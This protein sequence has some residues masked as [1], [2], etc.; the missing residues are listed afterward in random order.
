MIIS[1]SSTFHFH[2]FF[3]VK[4]PPK[5]RISIHFKTSK[6]EKIKFIVKN[7]LLS[8]LIGDTGVL[9]LPRKSIVYS[10]I[11]NKISILKQDFHR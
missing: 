3:K 9:D 5:E 10:I 1:L 7:S 11:I 4:V 6:H 2:S 8:G